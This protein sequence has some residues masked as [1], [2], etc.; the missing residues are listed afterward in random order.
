MIQQIGL[1]GYP[2]GH[3]ISPAVH[4]SAL[5]HYAFPARYRAW[6]TSPER[7]LFEVD[8]LRGE[9]YLGANITIPYKEHVCRFLDRVDSSVDAVGAVN[10]IVRCGQELVGYNTDTYGFE[11][12]L[13]EVAR[14]V[15]DGKRVLVL[16]AGGAARAAVSVLVEARVKSITI[17]NRTVARAEK[18]ADEFS[19]SS[20]SKDFVSFD[21]SSLKAA[22]V[23]VDLIVNATSVGLYQG[24]TAGCT[25]IRGESLGLRFWV[26][27]I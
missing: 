27:Q 14:F 23:G 26:C 13:S 10:T 18:L 12:S 11:R 8:K 25:P 21:G 20:C 6:S 24:P 7:I 1:L 16:G 2:L 22:C 9:E 19:K 15:P 17:A 5:D 3:S 4:Q